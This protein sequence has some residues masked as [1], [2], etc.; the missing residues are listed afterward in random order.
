MS[1]EADKF[2]E[3]WQK[4]VFLI[5]SDTRS[6]DKPQITP[7]SDCTAKNTLD[8]IFKKLSALICWSAGGVQI[9]DSSSMSHRKTAKFVILTQQQWGNVR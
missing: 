3:K 7:L 9:D 5:K 6:G 2:A 1:E 8:K 4:S